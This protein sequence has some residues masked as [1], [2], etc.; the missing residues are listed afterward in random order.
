MN[1]L[2]R[3]YVEQGQSPWLD[4]I[5]RNLIT[6]YGTA[7]TVGV[8][9]T[10]ATIASGVQCVDNR[11]GSLVTVPVDNFDAG[12]CELAENYHLGVGGTDGG[13]LIV[14]IT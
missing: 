13:V 8:N 7:L 6:S 5:R 10:G 11:F 1:N 14:V 9:G 2:H 12:E 3:L 4:N